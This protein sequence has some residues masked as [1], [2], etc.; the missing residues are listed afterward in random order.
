MLNPPPKKKNYSECIEEMWQ[1]QIIFI[2]NLLK[3]S[4]VVQLHVPG[5]CLIK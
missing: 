4:L 3:K 2:F 1:N 5:K